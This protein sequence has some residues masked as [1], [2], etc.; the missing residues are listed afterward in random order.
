MGRGWIEGD[1]KKN[2]IVDM[3]FCLYLY[4]SE[5][6][7]M[8]LSYSITWQVI[9]CDFMEG[10]RRGSGCRLVLC[11]RSRLKTSN[12]CSTQEIG[13]RAKHEV[14][15][16]IVKRRMYAP[17]VISGHRSGDVPLRSLET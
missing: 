9:T 14:E 4:N 8:R 6:L 15:F 10:V 17:S 1:K 12:R 3:K 7:V 2:V 13:M 16:D 5:K 11:A